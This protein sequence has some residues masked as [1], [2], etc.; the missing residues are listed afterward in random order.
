M[1]NFESLKSANKKIQSSV[2][3]KSVNYDALLSEALIFIERF[4]RTKHR[5]KGLLKQASDKLLECSYLKSNRSE[6]YIFQ[7]YIAYVLGNIELTNKYLGIA[8]YM[9]PESALVKNF[10]EM[11]IS[12][13]KSQSKTHSLSKSICNEK[14][15][16]KFEK[17]SS[18]VKVQK[19]SRIDRL[20]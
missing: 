14:P 16:D 1:I 17:E 2:N 18:Q 8:V 19:I 7:A 10:R 11:M 6:A 3:D 9:D 13:S 5:D 4:N 15:E 12:Q 20:K